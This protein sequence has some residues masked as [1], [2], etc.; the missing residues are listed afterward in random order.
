[1]IG[2]SVADMEEAVEEEAL[3]VEVA[4]E[5]VV[6]VVRVKDSGR[7]VGNTIGTVVEVLETAL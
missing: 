1:M 4:V 3:E 7:A 5:D 6:V 2:V